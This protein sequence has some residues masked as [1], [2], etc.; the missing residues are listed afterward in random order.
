MFSTKSR[1]VFAGLAVAASVAVLGTQTGLAGASDEALPAPAPAAVAS[2][3][4]PAEQ[5]PETETETEADD[6]GEWCD[7]ELH[8]EAWAEEFESL[9][10]EDRTELV[11]EMTAEATL[12]TT[13]LDDAGIDYTLETDPVTGIDWPTFDEDNEAAWDALDQAFDKFDEDFDKDFDEESDEDLDDEDLD[14]A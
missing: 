13:T 1:R 8:E 11:D 7:D 5:L 10:D 6:K 4:T 3:A 12:M 9:S 14:D 2:L